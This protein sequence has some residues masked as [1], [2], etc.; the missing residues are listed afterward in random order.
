VNVFIFLVLAAVVAYYFLRKKG[1]VEFVAET[2]VN[3]DLFQ[4]YN[5][6]MKEST[7]LKKAGKFEEAI[8]KIKEA[9]KEAQEKNLTLTAKDYLKLPPYLQKAGKNDEAWAWFNGLI[10]TFASDPM[11]LSQIYEKMGLFREREKNPKDAIKYSVLSNMY[12]CI[13]L[14]EQITQYGFTDRKTELK[15]RKENITDGYGMWQLLETAGYLHLEKDLKKII[16]EHMKEFP[17]IRIPDVVRDINKL[18]SE[19]NRINQ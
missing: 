2:L 17:N 13:G 9:Y 14:H 1:R 16:K 6:L 8:E 10:R 3:D 12:W 11:A 7:T 4:K 19:K 5:D 18:M 15:E